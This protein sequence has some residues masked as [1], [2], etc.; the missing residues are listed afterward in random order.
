M[1]ITVSLIFSALVTFACAALVA[2]GYSGL[3]AY[4]RELKE[5]EQAQIPSGLRE[6]LKSR[7]AMSWQSDIFMEVAL[8]DLSWS[9]GKE[10]SRKLQS[11]R[12]NIRLM[13]AGIAVFTV[14]FFAL[15]VTKK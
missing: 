6:A 14:L 9:H 15:L 11:V 3:V 1:I 2:S 5:E 10:V 8:G 4:L 7:W 13:G 12:K